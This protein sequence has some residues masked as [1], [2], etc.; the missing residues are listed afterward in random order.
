METQYRCLSCD[1]EIEIID[2]DE[3]RCLSCGQY[4]EESDFY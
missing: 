2:T 3:F 1:S 4:F